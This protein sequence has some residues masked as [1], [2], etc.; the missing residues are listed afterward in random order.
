MIFRPTYYKLYKKYCISRFSFPKNL[1]KNITN[2]N[3]HLLIILIGIIGPHIKEIW[4]LLNINLLSAK[5]N[6]IGISHFLFYGE[7]V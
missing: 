1:L 4:I 2:K 3:I 5:N 6:T 7:E